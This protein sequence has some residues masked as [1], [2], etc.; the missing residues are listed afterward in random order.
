MNRKYFYTIAAISAAAITTS[1]ATTATLQIGGLRDNDG[2]ILPNGTVVVIVADTNPLN[3][4]LPS[5]S[6]LLGE[7]LDIGDINGDDILSSFTVDSTQLGVLG[8]T[9][10]QFSYT[11]PASTNLGVYWFTGVTDPSLALTANQEYGF[12]TSTEINTASGGTINL[13][14]E[15]DQNSGGLAAYF[16]DDVAPG[17]G[18]LSSDFEADMT[19]AP[20]PSTALV[21]GIGAVAGLFRRRRG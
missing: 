21:L 3:G 9:S 12:F 5:S 17:S 6:D 1:L 18:I 14:S 13:V 16:S 8:S 11:L 4:G 15:P 7:T 20:E 2:N 10:E 19:V